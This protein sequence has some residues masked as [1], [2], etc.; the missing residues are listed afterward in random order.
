MKTFPE[1]FTEFI[2]KENLFY[3]KDKPL[4]AVSGGVDSVVLCELF[5]RS[6]FDFIIAHCNFQL[7]GEES[8]RDEHFVRGLAKKYNKEILVKRFD[9]MDYA[10]KNKVS[11]QVAARELRYAWFDEILDDWWF[12]DL[13]QSDQQAMMKNVVTAHHLT[14]STETLL[15]NFFKGTG[16]SGLHGILPKQGRIIRPLLFAKKEELISFADEN[17]LKWVEDSSNESEK[18]SRNYLRNKIIPSLTAIYPNIVDNLAN[19]IQRFSEV[20]I[21]Y[22]QSIHQHKRDLLEKK[23]NEIHIPVLKLKKTIPLRTVVYEIIKDYN[24][25]PHQVGE[26]VH[27]L[28]S[29]SGKYVQSTTHRIIKN[30]NWIIIAPNDPGKAEQI[31]IE[32]LGRWPFAGGELFL[33]VLPSAGSKSQSD[34]YIAF[35]DADKISFPLLVRKWKQG[36]YFYPLGMRKKKKLA[37]FFI[38]N[39]LSKP[40]KEKI[41]VIESNK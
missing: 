39:K 1:K 37:R 31:I 11:I 36:D 8:D 27:L 6:G 5:H 12:T 3:K 35:L 18:Y 22:N 2:R 9:L 34:N 13:R 28:D 19:N 7:R 30:R 32:S 4:L 16:I 21:L 26:V 40:D 20:E 17:K 29:E 25:Y 24:F 23:G 38:D 14:D 33:H 15:M 41:W 10:D